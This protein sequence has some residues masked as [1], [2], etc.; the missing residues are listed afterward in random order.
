[1]CIRDRLL[2]VFESGFELEIQLIITEQYEALKAIQ[3]LDTPRY[4]LKAG[5]STMFSSISQRKLCTIHP[6]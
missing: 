2:R 6:Q 4:A 3:S 5:L 1:M